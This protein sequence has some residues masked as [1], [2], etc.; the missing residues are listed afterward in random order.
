MRKISEKFEKKGFYKKKIMYIPKKD[1]KMGAA[2]IS[3][4]KHCNQGISRK[5]RGTYEKKRIAG[6]NFQ[7]QII[8]KQRYGEGR[9]R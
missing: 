8:Y 2:H 6:G 5:R 9:L 1:V 4:A 7:R 3:G